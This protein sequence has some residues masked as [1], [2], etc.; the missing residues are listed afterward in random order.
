MKKTILT[1]AII[2]TLAGC[3]PSV[4]QHQ[5]QAI[6][7]LTLDYI[8]AYKD[9]PG[10][11]KCLPPQQ[12]DGRWFTLCGFYDGSAALRNAGLWEL[13]QDG[14]SWAAYAANGKAMASQQLFRDPQVKPAEQPPQFDVGK[15]RALFPQ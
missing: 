11:K 10:S 6:D 1:A 12:L 2:S 3:G 4:P 5:Q 7:Q 8:M 9:A 14:T 15:A 13:R